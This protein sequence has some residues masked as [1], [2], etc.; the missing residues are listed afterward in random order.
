MGQIPVDSLKTEEYNKLHKRYKISEREVNRWTYY[1]MER[2]F[3]TLVTERGRIR[4]EKFLLQSRSQ[5]IWR[6]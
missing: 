6:F 5:R 3:V 1:N 2:Q 4:K